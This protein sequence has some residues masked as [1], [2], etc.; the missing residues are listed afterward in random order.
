MLLKTD[1]Y[2]FTLI[3]LADHQVFIENHQYVWYCSSLYGLLLQKQQLPYFD[4]YYMLGTELKTLLK[5][6]NLIF[7]HT[8]EKILIS[9]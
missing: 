4:P 8:K 2:P 6:P 3:L 5:L 1:S 7:L 9:L